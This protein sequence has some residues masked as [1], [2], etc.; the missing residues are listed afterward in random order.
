MNIFVG[1]MPYSITEEELRETFLPFGN[2]SRATVIKDR[3]TGQSRGFGFVEMPND[4][5]ADAAIRSLN[6]TDF[7]GRRLKVNQ[8]RPRE[9]RPARGPRRMDG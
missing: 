1:N 2:V 3:E 5:E 6:D 9:D 4:E 7:N 8:A